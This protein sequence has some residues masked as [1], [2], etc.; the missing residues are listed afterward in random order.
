[1]DSLE[2]SARAS[3]G[4]LGAAGGTRVPVVITAVGD[5]LLGTR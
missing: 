3:L 1:M 4:G 5:S 2:L